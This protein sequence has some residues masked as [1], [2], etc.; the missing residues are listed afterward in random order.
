MGLW[1][2]TNLFKNGYFSTDT[3]ITGDCSLR[4]DGKSILVG[5]LV[6]QGNL[7]ATS[8]Q[9]IN[10]GANVPTSSGTPVNGSDLVNKN[11]GDAN[12]HPIGSY[13]DTT[14]AQ[15]VG[16]VKSFTSNLRATAT[17]GDVFQA[18]KNTGVGNA[19]HL[20]F[21]GSGDLLYYDSTALESKWKLDPSGN[22]TIGNIDISGTL[23]SKTTGTGDYIRSNSNATGYFYAS[24]NGE[25]GYADSTSSMSGKRWFI[26]SGGGARFVSSS[27]SFKYWEFAGNQFR[28]Y[29]LGG[30]HSII[31]NGDS[32]AITTTGAISSA[33]LTTTGGITASATQTINFGANVPT[34]SG[35]PV[36]GS[37]L[38]NKTYGDANYHPIGSY[39]N[40]TTNQ[41]V[42]GVKT[43][44][45]NLV[46]YATT[47][48]VFQAFKNSVVGNAGHI[49]IN[50]GGDLLYYDS[51][52]AVSKWKLDPNG[53]LTTTGGITATASQ[54]ISF[55]SNNPTMGASNI[56]YGTAALRVGTGGTYSQK[57]IA[58]GTTSLSTAT[59]SVAIGDSAL[60]AATST[61]NLSV[62]IGVNSLKLATA[63]GNTAIGA[64]SFPLLTGTGN[65]NNSALGESTATNMTSGSYN[66]FLGMGSGSGVTSGANNLICGSSMYASVSPDTGTGINNN[67]C[68][69]SNAMGYIKNNMSNNCAVGAYALY[70]E[71][72]YGG[73][74]TVAIGPNAGVRSLG[75]YCTFIGNDATVNVANSTYSNA[76]ALGNGATVSASNQ[77][78]IGTASNS[79]I[80]PGAL[81][82]NGTVNSGGIT[83][84][85][86]GDIDT[87]LNDIY[88]NAIACSEVATNLGI[89]V[90][91]ATN[92]VIQFSGGA[93]KIRIGTTT[94]IDATPN[95]IVIGNASYSY[96]SSVVVGNG[97][98]M[99]V[100]GR[101]T[102]A[103]LVG[104]ICQS[105]GEYS[106]NV[107]HNA[108]GVQN[109][110]CI[111][112]ESRAGNSVVTNGGSVAIGKS[113]VSGNQAVAI[114]VD[115]NANFQDA[116]AIGKLATATQAG[117]VAVGADSQANGTQAVAIGNATTANFANAVSIG[118]TVVATAANQFNLGNASNNIL[119]SQT[120]YPWEISPTTITASSTLAASPLYGWYLIAT[121][122]A[123]TY[124]ITIPVITPQ[125]IGLVLNFRKIN[126]T[127]FGSTCSII[128]SAGNSYFPLN[129][130]TATTTSTAFIGG[131]A[132]TG[133]ILIINATQFG[134]LN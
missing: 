117:S 94:L 116:V 92:G 119:V 54:S 48:D 103:V 19:G 95:G 120:Y 121:T 14:T 42:G 35:T 69:G 75:S 3:T 89:D 61:V 123:G 91:D 131:T 37:D 2:T 40:T 109:S 43:F 104:N 112:R 17:T 47:G 78:K 18:Y 118:N 97:S 58:I 10:F 22:L 56:N 25:I 8:T 72:G 46:A 102:G 26:N 5:G 67:I 41:T 38:I 1:D 66:L 24:N 50:S 12:Y 57:S 111:G 21:N 74:G 29:N 122:A 128:S 33:S 62:A 107:G 113:S 130:V 108:I 68:I 84:T 71:V 88:T 45:S 79:T 20:L 124:T 15:N 49:I 52:A 80:I 132:T 11:Y 129:S 73:I 51:T 76:M 86:G 126:A 133:R 83:T 90:Q 63:I 13:V 4:N 81:T 64:N 114:G 59:N 32:G 110:V 60:N 93:Q 55:G 27:N 31:M 98:T 115:S 127:A 134:V 65:F 30:A 87:G 6:V 36:N 16:G 9:T 85:F 28:Y 34:S 101:G 39:V 53:L 125:M 7:T 70:A 96:G 100:A 99:T 105:L 82:V 106:V 23:I 77:I 44:T